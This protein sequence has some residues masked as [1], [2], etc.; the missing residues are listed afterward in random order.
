MTKVLKPTKK[1]HHRNLKLI[2]LVKKK[3]E[4]SENKKS[5]KKKPE[6]KTGRETTSQKRNE[7][8]ESNQAKG[9]YSVA[10]EKPEFYQN[11]KELI[12]IMHKL[13]NAVRKKDKEEIIFFLDE[14]KLVVLK[15]AP[16]FVELPKIGML[17]KTSRK[18]FADDP[19]VKAK[20]KATTDAMKLVFYDTVDRIPKSF[21][22]MWKA[23]N[24]KLKQEENKAGVDTTEGAPTLPEQDHPLSPA[25]ELKPES[26]GA[27]FSVP[28][29]SGISS[30][31]VAAPALAVESN[32]S[33]IIKPKKPKFSLGAMI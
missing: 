22:V 31:M 11:E 6:K 13:N 1:S 19:E 15:I 24:N 27:D 25:Q 33:V 2:H 32:P 10:K 30:E 17:I 5:E 4:N 14:L 29:K 3:K 8:V 9:V 23:C 26:R 16:S 28:R 7:K 18:T 12:P 20:I 21:K